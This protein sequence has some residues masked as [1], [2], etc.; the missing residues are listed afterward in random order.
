[1]ADLTSS[2]IVESAIIE[3]SHITTLYDTLTGTATYDN[4]DIAGSA[5]FATTS[6]YAVTASYAENAGANS[7]ETTEI[8]IKN[9][10]AGTIAK[11]TPCY[12]TGSGTSGNIAGVVPADAQSASLMPAGVIAAEE[13]TAGSEGSGIVIGFISGVNTAGFAAGDNVYV[14]V[15]GG[16]TNVKPTGSTNLIQKLGNVEKVDASNGSGV[17]L[18][19][20]RTN[21]LPNITPGYVWVG[22]SDGVPESISTSS[23]E[24]TQAARATQFNAN[25]I[26]TGSAVTS[27]DRFYLFMGAGN[28]GGGNDASLTFTELVGKTGLMTDIFATVTAVS[29][30]ATEAAISIVRFDS[31][32]GRIDFNS[33]N[34]NTQFNVIGYYI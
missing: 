26:P 6:S 31:G 29:E 19:A 30:S 21:D 13:L 16:Y 10:S 3:A 9:V 27:S 4:I 23:V 14:A 20:G 32:T 34:S 12:I 25:Y 22:D 2:S 15:G 8:T 18:G 1:M 24:V 28:T 11:G 33:Q 7:Q 17:I 5:S